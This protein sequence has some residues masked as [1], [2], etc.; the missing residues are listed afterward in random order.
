MELLIQTS[1]PPRKLLHHPNKAIRQLPLT[2]HNL[3][4][5]LSPRLEGRLLT[6]KA[7]WKEAAKPIPTEVGDYERFGLSE[8]EGGGAVEKFGGGEGAEVPGVALGDADAV[9]L[10]RG[11]VSVREESRGR[12]RTNRRRLR[13]SDRVR[14]PKRGR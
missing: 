3:P 12:R 6:T 10:R 14:R 9:C 4:N 2:I 7:E 1:I 5:L 8:K 11:E 13:G